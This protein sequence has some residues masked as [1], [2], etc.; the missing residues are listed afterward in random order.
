MKELEKKYSV[1]AFIDILG[2]KELI[3][4]ESLER[5]LELFN[6]LKEAIDKAIEYTAKSIKS[7]LEYLDKSSSS[8]E[9]LA[10]RLNV[11]QFSD[12]IYFSFDYS[13]NNNLDLYFGIYIIT[14][15]SC[16]Y[17][18]LMIGKGYFVRG[19]IAIGLNMV[20]DNFI[21]STALIKAVETEKETIYPRITMHKEL[22]DIFIEAQDNPFKAL[23]QGQLVQDWSE[24]VFLNPFFNHE[25]LIGEQFKVITP[26]ELLP[27]IEDISKKQKRLISKM[28][29]KFSDYFDDAKSK[30]LARQQISFNIK[31]YRNKQKSI[32]EKY[33][34]MRYFL[35]WVNRRP[36]ELTFKYV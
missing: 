13:N 14:A 32:Y 11:K 33:L 23:S 28:S 17:Q 30:S 2:Y 3:L 1:A 12:N 34:W 36:S 20:D 6:D 8:R 18:R 35:R 25:L 4:K 5:E 22:R 16:L 24:N 31:K 26:A 19:G 10:K 27:F 15:I 7:T 9:S 21:F 29:A